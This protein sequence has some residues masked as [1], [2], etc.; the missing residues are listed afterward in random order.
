[1]IDPV[2]LLEAAVAIP[3]P[4]GSERELARY[5]VRRMGSF[6]DRAWV[7]DAGSAVCQVGNGPCK[8]LFLGHID[9]VPGEVPVRIEGGRLY[10]RGSVD[11]KGPFCSALSATSRLSPR[12]REL[13]TVTL[14]GATEEEAPTSRGARYALTAYEQPDLLV[15][16]EPSGWNAITLGY[17]G[18]LVLDLEVVKPNH[19]SAGSESSAAEDAV[20][21][22]NAVVGWA[23]E[24]G[25]SGIFD[26]VQTTLQRIESADD[27]LEQ[28]C[29][30]KIGLRLPPALPPEEARAAL[31]AVLPVGPVYRFS[32]EELPY[33]GPKDTV[34]TRAFRRAIR[35]HGGQPRFKVKTGTSDM[36]VV[37]PF[38]RVP[39]LAYGAG[40][41]SLDHAPDEHV[42]VTDLR[43]AGDVFHSVLELLAEGV[44]ESTRT[45]GR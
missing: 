11:A 38:W 24:S 21:V 19:H 37:A 14:I 35:L 12:V 27:G 3:S 1:M 13:L 17:K 45:S 6:A 28:R 2:E 5:L 42:D 8:V 7:D 34:L 15:I 18:R 33:R 20:A 30:A 26:R 40:D 39:M 22:W 43:R 10:G 23:D 31:T 41:S 16:G 25:G 4:S 36:N 44:I 9:T 29:T 32:G